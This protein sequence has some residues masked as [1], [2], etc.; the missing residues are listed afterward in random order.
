MVDTWR[1]VPNEESRYP[2]LYCLSWMSERLQ[3]RRLIPFVVHNVGDRSTR[4]RYYNGWAPPTVCLPDVI[5]CDQISQRISYW[6]RSNTGCG[7][8][9]GMRLYHTVIP[10]NTLVPTP[11]VQHPHSHTI[12]ATPSFP[13]PRP[14]TL[15]PTPLSPH[16]H[17]HTISATPSFPHPHSHTISATPSGHCMGVCS[18]SVHCMRSL[19]AHTL[20]HI[21]HTHTFPHPQSLNPNVEAPLPVL[22][23]NLSSHLD[24]P[25]PS[26]SLSSS[27]IPGGGMALTL[28]GTLSGL[29]FLWK[30]KCQPTEAH[31]VS[32]LITFRQTPL[33][34]FLLPPFYP[35]PL[36]PPPS[37]LL[38]PLRNSLIAPY[39][40]PSFS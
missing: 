11:S 21:T 12:S 22:L 14:H 26:S 4:N 16:H 5:T 2:V 17:S 29:P 8:G 37:F 38:P 19:L 18:G 28:N 10:T 40:P 24:S 39:P 25:P 3:G 6:K 7:N 33:P 32:I 9:L 23:A 20:I 1:A 34:L 30:F 31:I 15:I 36:P 35:P 13:H 27:P